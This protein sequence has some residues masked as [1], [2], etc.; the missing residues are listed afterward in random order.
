[1]AYLGGK[2]RDW[3]DFVVWSWAFFFPPVGQ[4]L[5]ILLP[6]GAGNGH[7]GWEAATS[8]LGSDSVPST[9]MAPHNQL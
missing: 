2:L 9:Y 7:Y 4:G 8:L 1:M 5:I 3:W 6:Q